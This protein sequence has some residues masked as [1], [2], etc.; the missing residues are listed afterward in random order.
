MDVYSDP[1]PI[2]TV[3]QFKTALIAVK[4]KSGMIG[5]PLDMLKAHYRALP[6][7]ETIS[8]GFH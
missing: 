5:K 2:A 1:T 6:I 8:G 4:N 7:R 3:E